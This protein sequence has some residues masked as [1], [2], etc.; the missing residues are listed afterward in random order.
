M[1]QN[2]GLSLSS[3]FKDFYSAYVPSTKKTD[4]I[5]DRQPWRCKTRPQQQIPNAS[6]QIFC[7]WHHAWAADLFLFHAKVF[8]VTCSE[9]HLTA[10][11]TFAFR[12]DTQNELLLYRTAETSKLSF[13][14][15]H[16]PPNSFRNYIMLFLFSTIGWKTWRNSSLPVKQSNQPN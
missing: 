14:W 8:L 9:C 12:K 5:Y 16:P 10:F 13:K 6:L 7:V 3:I 15:T 2:L 4:S 1:S 11:V